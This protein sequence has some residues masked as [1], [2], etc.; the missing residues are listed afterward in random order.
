MVQ[1]TLKTPHSLKTHKLPWLLQLA[2]ATVIILQPQVTHKVTMT[3]RCCC[4]PVRKARETASALF[5]DQR[6]SLAN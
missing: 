6:L 5:V 4:M 1:V 2:Y 3:A